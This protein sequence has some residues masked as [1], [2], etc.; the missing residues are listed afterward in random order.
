MLITKQIT[1]TKKDKKND[2]INNRMYSNNSPSSYISKLWDNNIN[3]TKKEIV[4]KTKKTNRMSTGEEQI[5]IV[6]DRLKREVEI[7]NKYG[8]MVD[9]MNKDVANG[10][11]YNTWVLDTLKLATQKSQGRGDYT[12]NKC[13]PMEERFTTMI[14]QLESFRKHYLT[15][16]DKL[17]APLEKLFY[18]IVQEDERYSS[19]DV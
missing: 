1:K 8:K 9:F 14:E 15:W 16:I 13:K 5:Q 19:L 18:T 4:M 6:I 17:D 2:I 12:Q 7:I 11:K 10:D 3:K